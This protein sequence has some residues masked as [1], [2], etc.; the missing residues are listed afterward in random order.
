MTPGLDSILI[1]SAGGYNSKGVVPGMMGYGYGIGT[2]TASQDIYPV[3]N[4]KADVQVSG[5]GTSSN[6]FIVN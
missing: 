5:N 1:S 3:I 2:Q 6:P 4:I